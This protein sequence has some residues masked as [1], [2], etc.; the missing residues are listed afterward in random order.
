MP[1]ADEAANRDVQEAADAALARQ[2][3]EQE[4]DTG[5][6]SLTL[7]DDVD[8]DPALRARQRARRER[9]RRRPPINDEDYWGTEGREENLEF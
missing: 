7:S 3:Q 6:S 1:A 4:L 8:H 9:G 2:L 5:M